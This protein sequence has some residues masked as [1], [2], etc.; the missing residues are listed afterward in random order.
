MSLRSFT[1]GQILSITD[2]HLMCSMEGVYDILNHMTGEDL[3]TNQLPRAGDWAKP[4]LRARF[5]NLAD[6][7]LDH[8]NSDNYLQVLADLV[9]IHGD[10]FDV[11]PVPDY[12]GMNVVEEADEQGLEILD[13][14]DLGLNIR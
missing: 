10:A 1:L 14:C 11:E 3:F 13:I 12:A 8:V 4:I 9:A 7:N 2:G 6:I 5:P